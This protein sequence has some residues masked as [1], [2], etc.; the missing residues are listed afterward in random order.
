RLTCDMTGVTSTVFRGSLPPMPD[1]PPIS[2][3]P[4]RIAELTGLIRATGTET[5]TTLSPQ[6]GRDVATIP[7]S[8]EQDVADA[9]AAARVAQLNWARTPLRRRKKAL[10]RLHDL[11]LSHQDELLDLIQLESGKARS[12]AF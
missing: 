4:A 5:R 7:V 2:V 1:V 8:S 10:L 11:I 12:H 6:T 3:T 9:F